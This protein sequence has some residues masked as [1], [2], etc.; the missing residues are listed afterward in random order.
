[1]NRVTCELNSAPHPEFASCRNP[2]PAPLELQKIVTLRSA[3]S[4]GARWGKLIRSTQ[5]TSGS[6]ELRLS[7]RY[8]LT[9]V[10]IPEHGPIS[11]CSHLRPSEATYTTL[12]WSL[13]G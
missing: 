13:N 3:R 8:G 10:A 6:R 2:K 9:L 4:R 11:Y 12:G 7:K 5:D 1:M